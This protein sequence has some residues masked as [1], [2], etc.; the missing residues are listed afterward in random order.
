MCVSH[1]FPRLFLI[2]LSLASQTKH[3][4]KF[5]DSMWPFWGYK[6]LPHPKIPDVPPKRVPWS[7]LH[8]PSICRMIFLS[9]QDGYIHHLENH[10]GPKNP[11]RNAE[12]PANSICSGCFQPFLGGFSRASPWWPPGSFAWQAK[13]LAVIWA[14]GL[15]KAEPCR[16][17]SCR[18][19]STGAIWTWDLWHLVLVIGE[20]D[21]CFFVFLE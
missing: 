19:R 4:F 14:D 12:M 2:Q 9:F 18:G 13:R 1:L 17:S 10:P 20:I 3:C 16:G 21:L 5:G 11:N 7:K 8:L 15:G 6:L